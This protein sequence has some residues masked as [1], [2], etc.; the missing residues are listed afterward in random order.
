MCISDKLLQNS[1]YL[2]P[3]QHPSL[4]VLHQPLDLNT[5]VFMKALLD[6]P[7]NLSLNLNH[8]EDKKRKKKDKKEGKNN[9]K[10]PVG[11]LLSSPLQRRTKELTIKQ[12]SMQPCP[13]TE[14]LRRR[15]NS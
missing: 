13:T 7:L 4:E 8:T 9:T 5:E 10:D 12:T 1:M 3:R 6:H 15:G 14:R 2:N 11:K